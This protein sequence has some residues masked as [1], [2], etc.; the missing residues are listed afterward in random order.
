MAPAVSSEVT[1]AD[2]RSDDSRSLTAAVLW[3][4]AVLVGLGLAGYLIEPRLTLI[5]WIFVFFGVATVLQTSS[6]AVANR[7]KRHSAATVRPRRLS[8]GDRARGGY[9]PSGAISNDAM[10]TTEEGKK[11]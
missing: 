1:V 3:A 9:R 8:D 7:W 5:W 11:R 4:G 6:T 10:A 2:R